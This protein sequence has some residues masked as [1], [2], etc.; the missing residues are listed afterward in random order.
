MKHMLVT[1]FGFPEEYVILVTELEK[2]PSQRPT[3]KNILFWMNWL[4]KNVRIYFFFL[5]KSF[6]FLAFTPS[7]QFWLSN[8]APRSVGQ[9][10]HPEQ[11]SFLSEP[12]TTLTC[13][14]CLFRL[15]MAT[16]SFSTS[17]AM[18]AANDLLVQQW[19]K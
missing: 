15:L 14:F 10:L 13:P 12:C 9:Y 11:G 8:H 6:H 19:A 18:A 3:K 1:R 17:L 5:K 4:V 16:S 2:A 7:I